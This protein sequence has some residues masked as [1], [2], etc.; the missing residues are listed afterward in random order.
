MS[1]G[2]YG[3]GESFMFSIKP[4][5]KVYDNY[6]VIAFNI[7]IVAISLVCYGKQLTQESF[8]RYIIGQDKTIT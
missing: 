6:V 1:D 5:R 4:E 7:K 3:T 8:Y 2:Y